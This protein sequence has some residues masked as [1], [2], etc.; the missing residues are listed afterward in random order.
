MVDIIFNDTF[1]PELE[2]AELASDMRKH[3]IEKIKADA[4][5]APLYLG[6]GAMP[7]VKKV[8]SDF[9]AEILMDIINHTCGLTLDGLKALLA[10]RL[11]VRSSVL[12]RP[13]MVYRMGDHSKEK[14]ACFDIARSILRSFCAAITLQEAK[15][16]IWE[17]AICQELKERKKE[18]DNTPL[19]DRDTAYE[20]V[21][22]EVFANELK[23][24]LKTKA[25]PFVRFIELGMRGTE[26]IPGSA[27]LAQEA[28]LRHCGGEKHVANDL[29]AEFI[30]SALSYAERGL[31]A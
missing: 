13:V 6:A 4:K 26:E 31:G 3:F 12:D 23:V 14:E 19:I 24:A 18:L 16:E 9:Y 11:E 15:P 25:S 30:D 17:E 10:K 21:F 22:A 8:T 28:M 2:S 27:L 29:K 5:L 20:H 7:S 1:H